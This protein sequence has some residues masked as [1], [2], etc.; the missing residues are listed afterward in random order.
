VVRAGEKSINLSTSSFSKTVDSIFLSIEDAQNFS[1]P[2][3]IEVQIEGVSIRGIVNIGSDI[4]ILSRTASHLT[5]QL[6]L[7]GTT[8]SSYT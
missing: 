2:K 8:H 1:A 4:I 5:G 6:V 3:H 7:M